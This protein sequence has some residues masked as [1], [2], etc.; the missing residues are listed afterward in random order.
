M[1]RTPAVGPFFRDAGSP[2]PPAPAR[3]SPAQRSAG[4]LPRC[5]EGLHRPCPPSA[6]E[7]LRCP[8]AQELPGGHAEGEEMFY[9]STNGETNGDNLEYGAK[10]VVV[11]PAT[12]P[13][14]KGQGL[15]MQFP[16]KKDPID[17][18]LTQLSR[19]KPVRRPRV[20]AREHA[21]APPAFR[22]PRRRALLAPAAPC[23]FVLTFLQLCP[24]A[25][26]VSPPL[27]PTPRPPPPLVLLRS[28]SRVV[29]PHRYSV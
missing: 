2:H 27:P 6:N 8:L 21:C 9:T 20:A 4:R 3:V 1:Q 5:S 10:G 11:G 23:R 19:T 28:L 13:I 26:L 18:F 16:G 25:P 24:S 12:G 7:I 14:T 17:C 29:L 15:K 22:P